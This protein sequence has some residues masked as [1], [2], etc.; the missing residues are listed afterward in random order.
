MSRRTLSFLLLLFLSAVPGVR[1]DDH[2]NTGR[3][4]SAEKTFM[5]GDIDKV[6]T[7]NG[8]LVLTIPIGGSYPAGGDLSYGLTLIYNSNL[9]DF[10]ERDDPITQVTY[11]QG[12]PQRTSNA[13]LGWLL[14]LGRLLAP[15]TPGNDTER[16]VYQ[17]SDG[18]EHAFYPTLHAGDGDE[19]GD[20]LTFQSVSYTRDG[21]YLRMRILGAGQREIDFPSGHIHRIDFLN[22]VNQIRDRFNNA[23]NVAYGSLLW[24]LT[25]SQGRTHKIFF[26]NV[27]QDGQTI[28]VVDRVE[29]AAFGGATAVYDFSYA[30]TTIARGCP[31]NDPAIGTNVQ[32]TLLTGVTLPDGSAYQMPVSDYITELTQA[33]A[34]CRS[35]GAI[36]G[37]TLP[38]YGRLVWTYQDYVLPNASGKIHRS[39]SPGVKT[40]TT[41]GYGTWTYETS[42]TGTSPNLE[43][44]NTVIDP[45]LI[46]PP[47]GHR[48]VRWFVTP[49]GSYQYSQP[50]NPNVTDGAGRF[51]ST[52][53]F[54]AAGTLLRSTYVRYD[55]DQ[56]VA[57]P[58]D[59]QELMAV[60]HREASSRT[61][62]NDDGGRFADLNRSNFDG[63]GHYRT[64]A[65]GGNFGA[66][67]VRTT[68]IAYNPARGT[69]QIDPSTNLPLPGH[70]F[71]QWPSGQ[72]WVLGTFESQQVSEGGTEFTR[73]CFD[74]NTGFL[75]RQRRH[76]NSGSTE[77]ANDVLMVYTPDGAGNLQ[78]EQWLGGDKQN[79]TANGTTC[80]MGLPAPAYQINHTYQSGVRATSQY[81]GA[82]FLALDQ[83][84]DASS[85]L[86]LQSR[87]V[88]GLPTDFE[89]DTLGRLTWSKPSAGH[90]GWTEYAY[91]RALSISS[92]ANVLIRRRGNGSKTAAALAQNHLIFDSLGRLWRNN[93]FLPSGV[94]N[95]R[96]TLFDAAGN[97]ASVSETMTGNPT[98]KTQFLNYDPF[99]RAATIRPADGAGHDVTFNYFGTRIV[100][101]TAK[102]A[103]VTSGAES[104]ATTTETYDRQGR[105]SKVT[106]PSGAADALVT[107]TYN[108]DVG[109]RLRQ[110]QTQD[111]AVTQNRF[112]TYDN[113]GFLSS[114]THPEKGVSGNGN[115]NYSNYDAR[116]NVG[117]KID[118][119]N[120]LT[121]VYDAGER[122]TT[123]RESTGA[124][125]TLKSF[126]YS[127]SNGNYTDP[128]TGAV[129]FDYRKG[130]ITQQSRFNYVS[131]SAS[132][133][134]VELREGMNWCGRDGRL[135]RRSLDNYVNGGATPSESFFLPNVT[136]N[137]LGR[138]T[139]TDYP[140]CTHAACTASSP[141]IVNASYSQDLLTAV[142]IPGNNGYYASSITYH[143][144]L[145]VNQVVHGNSLTDTYANDPNGMRR[146]ASITVTTPASVVRWSTGN[147]G[148]DGAGNIKAIG[149]HTFA[150]DKVSRLKTG[151]LYLE[152]TTS[153]TL[154]TQT[155]TYDAFGN[156]QAIGGNSAR[157]TPTSSSTNRLMPPSVYDAVGNL[158]NWSGST[159]QYDPFN[160]MWNYR[161]ASDEWIY[162]YTADDERAWSYK[163]DNTSLWTLR[164]PSNEVLR[165]YSTIGGWNVA[166]DYIRRENSLLAA[167]TPQGIRHFHLDHLGTPR[168]VSNSGGQQTAYHIYYPF[169]EEATAFNQDMV[170]AKF[171]GHERDLRNPGGAGDDLDYMHARHC[172]PVTGRFLSVDPSQKSQD[173]DEP[174]SWNRY[175][176]AAGN[177]LK[178]VD[179]DG[180]VYE[181]RESCAPPTTFWG[182]LMKGLDEASMLPGPSAMAA[183]PRVA[184]R[185]LGPL[186]SKIGR[187][188]GRAGGTPVGAS[189]VIT[190]LFGGVSRSA[191][192]QAASSKGATVSVVTRLTQNP[193]GGRGLSVATGEGAEAL[194]NAARSG[195]TVFRGQIPKALLDQLRGAGLVIET[196]T[197][198]GGQKATELRFLP[199]ATEF[200]VNFLKQAK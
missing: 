85:G 91:S 72:S 139:S 136:Y 67:D 119:P 38:T 134:T 99:G 90:G 194:A 195:G 161:T 199:N 51:L 12:L 177:P 147:Y 35:S 111:G 133:F 98:Q 82:N 112:F 95:V 155:Y 144:N 184:S 148:Y 45:P 167:E 50:F 81:V 154:R 76:K 36:R 131:V 191:L 56:R 115:V 109:S 10:Q 122:L 7:F 71:T 151:N 31:H 62:F 141:R 106:E 53:T 172:S 29:L 142:G 114:E 9:W 17:G 49:P 150:Y 169:G 64:E 24:T 143:P 97:K 198:M 156:L 178:Y 174:Q 130:K 13:G 102:I 19:P 14:T 179:P 173:P 126:T 197:M 101:R 93:Q 116:G 89:Y 1:A 6:N 176:Y 27:T 86:T 107:T 61:V 34:V 92:P 66:G 5:V 4:F 73:Y 187:F 162:L 125:R 123:V 47:F 54:N 20:T 181:C 26:Q 60:N 138:I 88:S 44:K 118:G 100:E 113:R 40:R 185:F 33:S 74:A 186:I 63:L 127:G 165:E 43:L 2:P 128:I 8:N 110:V 193:Q 16:F 46:N 168:L 77:N 18:A 96:E 39:W 153:T 80:T 79:L 84:I 57:V 124:Q 180:M 37:L 137:P 78:S 75:L 58:A 152:P 94:W 192:Q 41:V 120:D 164:G 52:Q 15:N 11:T 22:R 65:T 146:P 32:V 183:G 200:V 170:R 117:R 28:E 55:A 21:S 23:L 171:T 25:D 70:N 196:T 104:S 105:L 160:L 48:T 157:N 189:E 83:T 159:Y 132:P 188:F 145:L 182:K 135:S 166:S 30:S 163:T 175:A 87:D 69:Y 158:T 140:R 42:L 121:F 103:T 149:T 129:C 68:T 190:G 108:Y 59:L 3:G